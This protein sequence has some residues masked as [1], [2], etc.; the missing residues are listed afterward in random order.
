M[1]ARHDPHKYATLQQPTLIQGFDSLSGLTITKTAQGIAEVRTDF[2]TEGTGSVYCDNTASADVL[3]VDFALPGGGVRFGPGLPVDMALRTYLPSAWNGVSMA[4]YLGSDAGFS[5]FCAGNTTFTEGK[6]DQATTTTGWVNSVINRATFTSGAHA[7]L[8]TGATLWTHMRL[9][10]EVG[11]G[12]VYFDSLWLNARSRPVILIHFDDVYA[13]LFTSF[14]A[15]G[16]TTVWQ[17]MQSLGLAGTMY[18]NA[19]FVGQAGKLTLAQLLTLQNTAGWDMANHLY[20]HVDITNYTNA[21]IRTEYESQRDWMTTNGLTSAPEHVA[22][23]GGG[24]NVDT[25][26]ALLASLGAKTARAIGTSYANYP[27]RIQSLHNLWAHGVTT[28]MPSATVI[29]NIDNAV[30]GGRHFMT[31]FHSV[32]DPSVLAQDWLAGSMKA[33]I[34]YIYELKQKGIVDVLTISQWYKKM[35]SPGR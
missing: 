14:A 20:N 15:F 3:T 34:D 11:R 16:N 25:H 22:Y 26:P 2:L 1:A 35:F 23:P 29:T 24:F 30:A 10:L 27:Y 21:A 31:Y 18:V 4:T 9:R 8:D 5:T 28:A 17:Y 7:N 6:R 32:A 19:S 12:P 33:V 13:S